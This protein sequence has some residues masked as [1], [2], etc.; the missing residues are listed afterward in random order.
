MW[1]G[2]IKRS[3]RDRISSRSVPGVGLQSNDG[4]DAQRRTIWVWVTEAMDFP[5]ALL[6]AA[7]RRANRLPQRRHRLEQARTIHEVHG[8]SLNSAGDR[9]LRRSPATF[10]PPWGW[11]R[12]TGSPTIAPRSP[13]WRPPPALRPFAHHD[14]FHEPHLQRS[15]LNPMRDRTG[16]N[17]W[18]FAVLL[19]V[20]SVFWWPVVSGEQL[21]FVRDLNLFAAPGKH[22]LM[23]RLH[24][25]GFPHWTSLMSAGMPFFADVSNQVLYP[26]NLV[27]L[28]SPSIQ[29]G[30]TWFVIAHSLL[31][32]TG[33][34]VLSRA[35]ELRRGV[36]LWAS[37]MYGLSGYVL[38]M[39]DNIN[40]LPACAWVPLGLAAVLHGTRANPARWIVATAACV[41]CLVLAGDALNA[42]ILLAVAVLLCVKMSFRVRAVPHRSSVVLLPVAAAFLAALLTAVQTLPTV[43]LSALSVRQA[44]LTIEDL[45]HWS[46]PP[47]RMLE[48]VQPF[49]F[50]AYY[51]AG[52]F[53]GA[54][55]YGSRAEAWAN[56]VYLGPV[57]V[58]LALLAMSWKPR[59]AWPWALVAVSCLLLSFGRNLPG[60]ETLVDVLPVV[61][62]QRFP[63]KLIFWVT[64]CSCL[65][66]GIG[67]DA[68]APRLESWG[69]RLSR[70]PAVLRMVISVLV[71]VLAFY[72]L[73]E[74]PAR[75]WIPELVKAVTVFW[76]ARGVEGQTHLQVLLL[77]LGVVLFLTLGMLWLKPR[78][79][80]R[81]LGVLLIFAVLDLVWIHRGYVLAAP[82]GIFHSGPEPA[83]VAAIRAGG[84][85]AAARIYFDDAAFGGRQRDFLNDLT[86]WILSHFDSRAEA[87]QRGYRHLFLSLQLR[88]RLA[89][90]SAMLFDV[91]YL[92]GRGSPL[93]P[94]SHLA[95]ERAGM[96]VDPWHLLASSGVQFV[97]T[98]A[99]PRH[100]RWSGPEFEELIAVP[101]I[102]LRLLRVTGG[103]PRVFLVDAGQVQ[104]RPMESVSSIVPRVNPGQKRLNL[105]EAETSGRRQ[106]PVRSVRE[107]SSDPEHRVVHVDSPYPRAWLGLNES[108]FPGWTATIDGEPATL[109]LMNERFMAVALPS[110]KH[111]VEFRYR[112]THLV[113]GLW[114][115]LFGFVVCAWLLWRNPR[116]G[117][118]T[119]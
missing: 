110:G 31:A 94:L 93:Q 10:R 74:L 100:S 17:C 49:F 45:G 52:E 33:A 34:Y 19:M 28:A 79:Q 101:D 99:T 96:R 43:E 37:L 41:V 8:I 70:R 65:L 80:G 16:I 92:N 66:A 103:L 115:S 71:P 12:G 88:H 77:H 5:A 46:F 27:F 3:A 117:T 40:Y 29:Q 48:F 78:W 62:T 56:S 90:N 30:L 108:L 82:A 116:S 95:L 76:H 81:A 39:S 69:A 50:G 57:T 114:I 18:P 85:E 9:A 107:R 112:P 20:W 4:V 105:R 44:G 7:W 111:E 55:L 15:L 14:G 53:L 97:V 21:L 38:S 47:R 84:G 86:P 13:P 89:P 118:T 104:E 68:A 23:E 54:E 35:M 63:E 98:T 36:A 75:A 106:F 60:F 51:P 119:A 6:I 2:A 58:L 61:G 109:H 1:K 26:L 83:A 91:G 64:L 102:N 72:L 73:L 87:V 42:V 22:Y 24:G 59:V 25:G 32:L 11:T 113:V 67:A